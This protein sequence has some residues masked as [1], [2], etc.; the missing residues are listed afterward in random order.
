MKAYWI[1]A[2]VLLR[3]ITDDP[4]ELA[5]RAAE[6]FVRPEQGDIVLRVAP[7]IVAEVVWV[8]ISFYGY[9]RQQVSET[10]I[11]ML[12]SESV[13]LQDAHLVVP[14]LEQMA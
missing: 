14:A 7:I 5:E 12:T 4:P 8:L 2:N 11:A 1:D 6:L 9:S 13:Y 10:L 3:L